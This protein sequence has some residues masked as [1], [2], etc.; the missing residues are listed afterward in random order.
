MNHSPPGAVFVFSVPG[1]AAQ[2]GPMLVNEIGRRIQP[3]IDALR[4]CP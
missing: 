3:V 2:K 1:A 4:R